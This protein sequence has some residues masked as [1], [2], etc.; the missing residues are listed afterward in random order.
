MV[1]YRVGLRDGGGRL[2]NELERRSR[3]NEG[4]LGLHRRGHDDGDGGERSGSGLSGRWR[5]MVDRRL[6]KLPG[7]AQIEAEARRRGR[8]AE[9]YDITGF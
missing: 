4:S 2:K 1:K 5:E 3:A 9:L 6:Y 8:G 7:F